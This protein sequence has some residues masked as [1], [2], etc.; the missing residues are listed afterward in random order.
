MW[1]AI[2]SGD[3]P[4]SIEDADNVSAVGTSFSGFILRLRLPNEMV[5]IKAFSLAAEMACM[6]VWVSNLQFVVLRRRQPQRD[7][8]QT[9]RMWA[10]FTLLLSCRPTPG[11]RQLN[12]CVQ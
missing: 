3:D 7:S 6:K 1:A 4:Y 12:I 2:V 10:V 9:D 8:S 5:G 11:E